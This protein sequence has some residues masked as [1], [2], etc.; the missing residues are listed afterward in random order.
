MIEEITLEKTNFTKKKLEK[1]YNT[2]KD[3]WLNSDQAL[4]LGVIDEI[5]S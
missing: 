2:K 1:I 5:I 4:E 3:L